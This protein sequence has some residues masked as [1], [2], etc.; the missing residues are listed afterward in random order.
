[1]AVTGG[2]S[3][4]GRGFVQRFSRDGYEVK[5]YLG[6]IYLN[7]RSFSVVETLKLER[8]FLLKIKL[9]LLKLMSRIILR[10]R[11]FLPR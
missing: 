7:F 11:P 8:K 6:L 4:L 5:Q 10:S 2:T 9:L 3:G 1:M